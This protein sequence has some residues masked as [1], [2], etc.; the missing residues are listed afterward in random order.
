MEDPLTQGLEP[1]EP[2]LHRSPIRRRKNAFVSVL[3]TGALMGGI[4]A[5]AEWASLGAAADPR[6]AVAFAILT[7]LV[8]A[9]ARAIYVAPEIAVTDRRLLF[10]SGLKG[11][12]LQELALRDITEITR[13]GTFSERA[14]LGRDGTRIDIHMLP[15]EKEALAALQR[16]MTIPVRLVTPPRLL[17]AARLALL[18][19][20]LTAVIAAIA[21]PILTCS[22]LCT[23]SAWLVKMNLMPASTASLLVFL[24]A[25]GT[26]LFL[27]AIVGA[28]LALL[29]LRFL[30]TPREAEQYLALDVNWQSERAV[31]RFVRRSLVLSEVFASLL[32][33]RRIRAQRPP[34]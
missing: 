25:G 26:M 21:V 29:P 33:G 18:V 20:G 16:V 6:T 34:D 8:H 1:G 4:V 12:A 7:M 23:W 5:V 19:T 30:L 9:S 15:D 3:R 22:T 13:S 2:V 31:H 14:I 17:K 24:L 10:L 27:G 32:Y 28:L 11:A